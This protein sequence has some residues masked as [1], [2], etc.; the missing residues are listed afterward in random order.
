[1][2]VVTT[3]KHRTRINCVASGNLYELVYRTKD[4][5]KLDENAAVKFAR[6]FHAINVHLC[7]L[8]SEPLKN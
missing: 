4:K 7:A 6:K 3:F 8:A 5:D 1:M 2:V